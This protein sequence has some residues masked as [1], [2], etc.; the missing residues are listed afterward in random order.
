MN[1][2][3][4][5]IL[6]DWSDLESCCAELHGTSGDGILSNV[7][8]WSLLWKKETRLSKWHKY[9]HNYVFYFNISLSNKRRN[10]AHC[11]NSVGG[12]VYIYETESNVK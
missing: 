9:R 3:Q 2:T 4:H 7:T 5:N 10:M 11:L 8:P 12:F 6:G 1:K